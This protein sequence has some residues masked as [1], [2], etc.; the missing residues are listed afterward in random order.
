MSELDGKVAVVTGGGRGIGAAIAEALAAKGARVVVTARSLGACED[1]AAGIRDAGGKAEAL[2]CDVSRPAAVE[3]MLAGTRAAFGPVDI[4][5]NNAGVIQPIGLLAECDAEAWL[6]NVRI[7]LGGAFLAARAVIPAMVERGGG[8]IV[9][10][11]SGAAHR[12]LEGWSAYCAGKAGL[13]MLTG[14]LHLEYGR[15]GIRVFGFGPGTVDTEMQVQIRASG[16][17]QIS[18]LPRESLAKVERPAAVVAWLCG[19]AADDLAGQELS[20]RDEE[21][22]KRV[23]L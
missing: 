5:V 19:K 13:A 20:I 3:A 9:N 18:K 2:A 14:S 15:Q 7:N 22:L 11:S 10:I 12:P 4:L 6:D 17:N 23:G 1:V 21:L 8:T 16:I